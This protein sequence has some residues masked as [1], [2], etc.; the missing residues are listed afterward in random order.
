MQEASR[1]Q[2]RRISQNQP[3]NSIPQQG[4]IA[5]QVQTVQ[6]RPPIAS[7]APSPRY[8][9]HPILPVAS[10]ENSQIGR[11][12]TAS[13]NA[14]DHIYETLPGYSSAP[15]AL[16]PLPESTNSNRGQLTRQI[17]LPSP[18]IY[19]EQLTASQARHQPPSY[20]SVLNMTFTM[21]TDNLRQEQRDSR[22][23]YYEPLNTWRYT[24]KLDVRIHRG[25]VVMNSNS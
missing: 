24:N 2:R 12:W 18:P 9:A 22:T 5:S 17:S 10:C 3:R 8:S 25:D 7:N 20:E 13:S 16:N 23:N 21:S 19:Q 4:P 6:N 14:N 11:N 15:I 1:L